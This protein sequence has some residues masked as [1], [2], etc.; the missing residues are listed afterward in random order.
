MPH[1]LSVQHKTSSPRLPF[2][3]SIRQYFPL[4]AVTKGMLQIYQELL[5]LT[6]TQVK[7]P[8]VWHSDV[9]QHPWQQL[10]WQ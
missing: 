3:Q 4:D 10:Q 2:I 8:H 5:G 7:N 6:Y 1:L 9:R